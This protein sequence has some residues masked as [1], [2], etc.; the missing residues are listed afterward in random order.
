[1]LHPTKE[2]AATRNTSR[3]S[4]RCGE[5]TAESSLVRQIP[6]EP[7]RFALLRRR[8]V[9]RPED[10]RARH[11]SCRT[12]GWQLP[13]DQTTLQTDE[14]ASDNCPGHSSEVGVTKVKAGTS[15]DWSK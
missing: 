1:M 13:A 2:K 9:T 15:P 11:P 8:S 12:V 10:T 5:G 3:N 4:T 7:Q 6:S 14:S